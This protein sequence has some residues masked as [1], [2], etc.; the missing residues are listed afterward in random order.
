MQ[1]YYFFILLYFTIL[2]THQ[3]EI[4]EETKSEIVKLCQNI[5]H[6]DSEIMEALKLNNE[7]LTSTQLLIKMS[8]YNSVLR[9]VSK[10]ARIHKT[11][12]YKYCQTIVDLG[13]P[14][15]FQVAVDDDFLQKC[16][17]F[18]EEQK[19]EI[20]NIRQIAVELWTDFHKTLGI[21]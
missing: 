6:I 4:C 18:T 13:L 3:T 5:W 2:F 19:R 11:L 14:R 7:T 8:G 9:E 15:Y 12:V 17:N 21:Q 1:V 16:L 10:R 20:Y